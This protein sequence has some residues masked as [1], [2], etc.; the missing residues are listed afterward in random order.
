MDVTKQTP[1]SSEHSAY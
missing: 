1:P